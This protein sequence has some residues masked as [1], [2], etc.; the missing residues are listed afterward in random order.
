MTRE[1]WTSSTPAGLTYI[2]DAAGSIVGVEYEVL[3]RRCFMTRPR[4]CGQNGFPN[5]LIA[6]S[7]LF[8]AESGLGSWFDV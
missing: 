4:S 1:I 5:R 2:R 6:D 7:R 3:K 8:F